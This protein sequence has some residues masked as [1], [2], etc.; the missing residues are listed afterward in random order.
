MLTKSSKLPITVVPADMDVTLKATK[1]EGA[2]P[3]AY[4]ECFSAALGIRKKA[5]IVKGNPEF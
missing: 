2:H 3:V 5:S 1:L 4:A